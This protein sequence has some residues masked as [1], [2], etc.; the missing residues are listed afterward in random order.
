VSWLAEQEDMISIR[1][2]DTGQNPVILTAA[3]SNLVVWLPL[4]VLQG[5]VLVCGIMVV[6]RRRRLT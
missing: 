3:Q 4:V 5:A 1:P 2:K 6:V